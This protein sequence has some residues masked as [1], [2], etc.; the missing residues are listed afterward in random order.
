MCFFPLSYRVVLF[1]AFRA[2]HMGV[3]DCVDEVRVGK[4]LGLSSFP[5]RSYRML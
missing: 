2:L 5:R 3:V 4:Y 1:C